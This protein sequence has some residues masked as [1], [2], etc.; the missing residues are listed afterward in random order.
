[1]KCSY[2]EAYQ[3]EEKLRISIWEGELGLSWMAGWVELE[4]DRGMMMVTVEVVDAGWKRQ[5]VWREG[6]HAW[7]SWRSGRVVQW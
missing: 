3:G 1:L 2:N 5:C 7:Q 6:G 4:L